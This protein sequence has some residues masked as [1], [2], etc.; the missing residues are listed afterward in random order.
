MEGT[1]DI[2]RDYIGLVNQ[3]L[4]L[5]NEDGVLVFSNNMR[6]FKLDN[7]AFEDVNIENITQK[8]MPRDFQRNSKI[9]QAWL[10]TKI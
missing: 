4:A 1:L 8:T 6:K 5:L 9:H 2:Q 3:A 7:E 10:F